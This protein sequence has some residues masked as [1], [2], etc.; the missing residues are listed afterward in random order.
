[1]PLLKLVACY[2]CSEP[3]ASWLITLT[4]LERLPRKVRMRFRIHA[5]AP[6]QKK[7]IIKYIIDRYSSRCVLVSHRNKGIQGPRNLYQCVSYELRC[8]QWITPFVTFVTRWGF[9]FKVA[10][11]CFNKTHIATTGCHNSAT[12]TIQHVGVLA[13]NFEPCPVASDFFQFQMQ[14]ASETHTCAMSVEYVWT[15]KDV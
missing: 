5:I 7:S 13:L 6:Y 12:P 9:P 15:S 10:R 4:Y 2:D 8:W 1:M 3:A 11:L 14:C